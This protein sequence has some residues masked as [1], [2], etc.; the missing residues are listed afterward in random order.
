MTFLALAALMLLTIFASYWT[1]PGGVLSNNILA[2]VIASAKAFLVIWIFMGIKWATK[3]ARLWAV[4]GFIVFPLMFIMFQD[5]FARHN[6]IVPSWGGQRESALPRVMDP[7]GN[8]APAKGA[9]AGL[10]PRG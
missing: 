1:L 3:L 2:M 8:S 5:F 7:V 4:A 9:S 6:E 10:R